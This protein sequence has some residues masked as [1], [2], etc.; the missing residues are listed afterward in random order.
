MRQCPN[1][2]AY[3]PANALQ[4]VNGRGAANF[5]GRGAATARRGEAREE[6]ELGDESGGG[7]SRPP[8]SNSTRLGYITPRTWPMSLRCFDTSPSFARTLSCTCTSSASTNSLSASR[9]RHTEPPKCQTPHRKSALCHHTTSCP[10]AS[11]QK[12]H[13]L[14]PLFPPRWSWL[15]YL[16][17]PTSALR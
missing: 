1:A 6:Q 9:H 7:S 4:R 10:S 3:R 12:S 2:S 13:R 15:A 8:D 17:P 14:V 16:C 5:Q 11:K